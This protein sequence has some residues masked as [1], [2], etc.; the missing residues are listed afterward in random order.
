MKP[1][2]IPALTGLR[3]FAAMAIVMW[4]SQTGYFFKY[5]AFAPFY[6]AG[7]VPVFFVLSGFV[8]TISAGK[9]KSWSD[10]FVARIA[11]IWPTHVAALAFLFL[12]FWPYSVDFFHH[13]DTLRRLILNVLLVQAWSPNIATYWSYNDP[14]WSVSGEM[15]F[16]ATL[17]FALIAL[18]RHTTVRLVAL[19]AVTFGAIFLVATAF[20]HIDENW[21]GSVLPLSGLPTFATGVAVGIWYKR[22]PSPNPSFA[23]GTAVQVCV[24]AMTLAANAL[25]ASYPARIAPAASAFILLFGPSPFYAALIFALARYDGAISRALSL[26]L[27]VYGG[28]ISYAIYLFHQL[29]FRWHSGYRAEFTGIPIWWQYAGLIT[30]V[31]ATSIVAHHVVEGPAKKGIL[32]LWGMILRRQAPQPIVADTA[33]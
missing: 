27:I 10:F 16:Y 22:L 13:A 12:I 7:A 19:I 4:H 17:P 25:F 15:F 24:L 33:D 26:R 11:R 30:A 2:N 32:A 5:G 8:L 1:K 3:F 18:S 29:F 23:R 14:S 31:L 21:L 6:L 28:E 9:Y 20:P